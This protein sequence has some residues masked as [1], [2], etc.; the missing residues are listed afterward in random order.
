MLEAFVWLL[1]AEVAARRKTVQSLPRMW[2]LLDVISLLPAAAKKV[3]DPAL[4]YKGTFSRQGSAATFVMP[5]PLTPIPL[6]PPCMPSL[7][8]ITPPL[9]D[10]QAVSE[11]KPSTADYASAHMPT[12]ASLHIAPA[13]TTTHQPSTAAAEPQNAAE[14]HSEAPNNNPTQQ[15]SAHRPMGSMTQAE[16]PLINNRPL[17]QASYLAQQ[18]APLQHDPTVQNSDAC[19]EADL[20]LTEGAYEC[21]T[22]TGM[23]PDYR[24]NWEIPFTV[25]RKLRQASADP[26]APSDLEQHTQ[27]VLLDMPLPKRLLNLREKHEMLYHC[28]VCQ[29]GCSLFSQLQQEAT[30]EPVAEAGMVAGTGVPQQQEALDQMLT[31]DDQMR[32]YWPSEDQSGAMPYSPSRDV[33]YPPSSHLA[34][35]S[36]HDANLVHSMT[37]LTENS[38]LMPS[39]QLQPAAAAPSVPEPISTHLQHDVSSSNLSGVTSLAQASASPNGSMAH[40]ERQGAT[41]QHASQIGRPAREGDQLHTATRHAPAANPWPAALPA[42][43]LAGLRSA[44]DI[45]NG[46]ALDDHAADDAQGAASQGNAASRPGQ[47]GAFAGESAV[48]ASKLSNGHDVRKDAI[49]LPTPGAQQAEAGIADTA[50]HGEAGKAYNAQHGKAGL[51]YRSY[52]LGGYSVVA[53]TQTPLTVSPKPLGKVTVCSSMV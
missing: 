27:Q 12:S 5:E 39:Q 28:A 10:A 37:G 18:K 21:L 51:S 30:G 9:A 44:M 25:Q 26:R 41:V 29:M 31:E 42:A 2:Q 20:V 48:D 3:R 8:P 46:N 1:Q 40:K 47:G 32:T 14:G 7:C 35:S 33:P 23:T 16:S 24:G 34:H 50:P 49:N 6:D 11:P 19:Q 13:T 53:R 52:R 45:D 36:S 15:G 17:Q 38:S 4:M 43:A 22:A